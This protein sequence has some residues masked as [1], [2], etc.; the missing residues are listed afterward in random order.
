MIPDKDILRGKFTSPILDSDNYA[1]TK[2]DRV[3]PRGMDQIRKGERLTPKSERGVGKSSVVA[4]QWGFGFVTFLEPSSVDKVLTVGTH[5]L[6]GKKIDPKVAFP[7]RTHPK[8]TPPLFP[9]SLPPPY[10]DTTIR[11]GSGGGWEKYWKIVLATADR[12]TLC[13]DNRIERKR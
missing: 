12:Q 7:R 9:P 11:S 13:Q 6:D 1:S 2:F 10:A 5:E 4:G 8:S 3:Q